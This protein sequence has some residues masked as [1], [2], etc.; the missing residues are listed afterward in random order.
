MGLK[1]SSVKI[2]KIAQTLS[3]ESTRVKAAKMTKTEVMDMCFRVS[4]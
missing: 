1:Y 3:G 2:S 4:C